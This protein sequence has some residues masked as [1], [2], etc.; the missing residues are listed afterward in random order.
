MLVQGN[1]VVLHNHEKRTMQRNIECKIPC[2][3]TSE[4]ERRACDLGASFQWRRCQRDTYFPVPS[5]RLKLR[6]VEG[7]WGEVIFYRRADTSGARE[8][9]YR[10]TPEPDPEGMRALLASALGVIVTVTKT[11]TLYLL[12]S[13]RLHIDEVEELGSFV[14]IEDVVSGNAEED[15]SNRRVEELAG[16][17]G[18]DVSHSVPVSYADLLLEKRGKPV[19]GNR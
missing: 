8:S 7:K 18:L 5:G 13:T 16:R 3:D 6:E 2:S 12:G 17:L 15:D 1:R 14:E 11:R 9:L 10:I 4:V 19:S